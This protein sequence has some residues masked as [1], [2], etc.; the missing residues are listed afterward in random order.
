MCTAS[1]PKPAPVQNK[2]VQYLANPWLD[3]A[4]VGSSAR[5]RNSLRIDPG[6]PVNP[7]TAQTPII[8]P[9]AGVQTPAPGQPPAPGFP[10]IG[11]VTPAVPPG[12]LI[13]SARR[14][15]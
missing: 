15:R 11:V 4:L 1:V 9:G 6:S 10:G 7:A 13:G 5:G 14:T 2:P 12:L 3:G 8:Q